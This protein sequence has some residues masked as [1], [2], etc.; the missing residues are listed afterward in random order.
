MTIHHNPLLGEDLRQF[1]GDGEMGGVAAAG[2]QAAVVQDGRGGA[3]G[4]QPATGSVVGEDEGAHAGVGAEEFGAGA[5][6]EKETVGG[7]GRNGGEGR[8]GV[9]G[10]A[11]TTG[12]VD[13]VAE[14][15]HDDVGA[16]A[17]EQ[18]DGGECFDL[19]KTFREDCENGGH[20]V[21]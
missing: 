15:G 10:H 1:I 20:A 5:A 16:G 19:L 18:I 17:A 9:N 11:G 7:L 12:D 6:R 8:V 13:A 2:E 4:G 3:D 14:R 21:S